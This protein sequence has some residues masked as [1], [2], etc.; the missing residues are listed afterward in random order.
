V[1]I[2]TLLLSGCA[3]IS[4]YV[5]EMKD[6]TEEPISG[7]YWYQKFTLYNPADSTLDC[8]ITRTGNKLNLNSAEE[9]AEIWRKS[10]RNPSE[11]DSRS[12]ES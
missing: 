9:R 12:G 1:I 7:D 6:V 11:H 3:A 4:P 2:A 10:C 5:P 8:Q